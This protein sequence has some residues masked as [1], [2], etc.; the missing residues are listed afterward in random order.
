MLLGQPPST[1]INY[2]NFQYWLR[3]F[4]DCMFYKNGASLSLQ[5]IY[6]PRFLTS[7]CSAVKLIVI[8]NM[9]K[10]NNLLVSRYSRIVPR[11]SAR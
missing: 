5:V 10:L 2:R 9:I 3:K 8:T 1:P 4:F 7:H 6:F 11:T